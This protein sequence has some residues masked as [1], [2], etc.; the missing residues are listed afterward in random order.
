[1]PQQGPLPE[2]PRR[3]ANTPLPAPTAQ[4]PDATHVTQLL[5]H[6]VE[7]AELLVRV[8][9]RHAFEADATIERNP[10]RPVPLDGVMRPHFLVSNRHVARVPTAKRHVGADG[11]TGHWRPRAVAG[12]PV[13]LENVAA[14]I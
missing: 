2:G 12:V 8:L 6:R 11:I 14:K 7:F 13:L 4:Q 5:R 1:M 9:F 10:V 3:I